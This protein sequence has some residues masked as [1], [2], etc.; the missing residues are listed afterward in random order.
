[1]VKLSMSNFNKDEADID[2]DLPVMET[3]PRIHK[4]EEKICI[5]CE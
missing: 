1:M 4:S 2:F 3:K 5:A